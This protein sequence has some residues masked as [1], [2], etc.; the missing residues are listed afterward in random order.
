MKKIVVFI[1]AAFFLSSC[2]TLA[3]NELIDPTFTP[4]PTPSITEAPKA[5]D[6]FQFSYAPLDFF[7]EEELLDYALN[8][9]SEI[10][11]EG[12]ARDERDERIFGTLTHYYKFRTP[13]DGNKNS[14]YY[15]G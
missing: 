13:P 8:V 6:D 14:C 5:D 12:S 15:A 7:S 1:L 11:D 4:S 3:P 10:R 9:Q 2:D